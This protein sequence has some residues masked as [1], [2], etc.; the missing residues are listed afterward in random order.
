MTPVNSILELQALQE[1]NKLDFN[2][3]GSNATK[4][5]FWPVTAGRQSTKNGM[6]VQAIPSKMKAKQSKEWIT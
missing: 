3:I 6:K 4:P 5:P 2:N 1:V